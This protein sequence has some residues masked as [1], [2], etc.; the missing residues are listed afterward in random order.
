MEKRRTD[1]GFLGQPAWLWSVGAL[2]LGLALS[3]LAASLH[4]QA[5]VRAEQVRLDRLA[6][7]SFD[8]VAAKLQTCGLLVRSVQALFLSSDEVTADVVMFQST[9]AWDAIKTKSGA[10]D[11]K[12]Y[13]GGG[14]MIHDELGRWPMI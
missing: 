4:H 11:E 14:G 12:M 6:E 5:L 9:L 7:R 3:G 2:L 1:G 8:A 13:H 10:A